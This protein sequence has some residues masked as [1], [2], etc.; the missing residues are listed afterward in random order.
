MHR[1]LTILALLGLAT[2]AVAI[3]TIAGPAVTRKNAPSIH[4]APRPT[5]PL[6]TA[7]W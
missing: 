5:C 3:I 7:C 2:I 1:K 4:L 6:A